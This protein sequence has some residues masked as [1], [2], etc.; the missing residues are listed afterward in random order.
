MDNPE[1]E[2]YKFH[3]YKSYITINN[4][5]INKIAVS[6]KVPFIK[7]DFK[8]FIGYKE[9]KKV[10]PLCIFFPKTGEYRRDF[11]KANCKCFLI[12]D[13]KLWEKYNEIWGSVSNIIK[14]ELSSNYALCI[15][16]KINSNYNKIVKSYNGKTNSKPM[17]I[18]KEG[19]QCIYLSVKMIDSV[20]RKFKS[21]FPKRF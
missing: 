11:D 21:Y 10:R 5:D 18:P 17:E 4:I 12:K 19:S 20:Y 9:A 3:Q 13:K 6:N 15:H 1:I 2:K 8:Y 14:K 16:W 7:K